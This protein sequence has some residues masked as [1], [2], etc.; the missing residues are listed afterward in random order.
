MS[1]GIATFDETIQR[2]LAIAERERL[3]S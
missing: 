2:M 1:L 3:L